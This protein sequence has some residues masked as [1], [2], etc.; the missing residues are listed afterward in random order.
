MAAV[1]PDVRIFTDTESLSQAA[2]TI[3]V[4]TA[5]E[6]IDRRGVSRISLSGGS[7]PRRMYSILAERSRR[8]M[9]DWRQLQFYWGD[10]RC[11]PPEDL[12]S[13]YHTARDLLLSQVPV[14][15]Q[16]IYRVRTELEPELAAQDYALALGRHAEPPL[17]WPRFDLVLLGLGDDGHTASLFPNA[18]VDPG[19]AT[20]AVRPA[21]A[22]PPGWRVSLTPDVFN[23]ARRIVFLVEGARKSAI[24][25]SVLYGAFQPDVL[26]AQLIRPTDGELIWLMDSGAA[27]Q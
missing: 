2:A 5:R 26:P 11:V 15:P 10:E 24:V 1:T 3:F 7:S 8:N 16:N 4:E 27:A 13:N 6:A 20:V 17:R 14:P 21:V 19:T 25:A 23:S 18:S 22:D 9:V 12:N